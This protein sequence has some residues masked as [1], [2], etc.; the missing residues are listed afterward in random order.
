MKIGEEFGEVVAAH[1]GAAGQNPRKGVS[2][3]DADVVT[4]LCDVIITA[5]V[6]AATVAG[7]AMVAGDLFASRV[8]AVLER[9]FADS[10]PPC[11]SCG[12]L[13][14][15]WLA[16]PFPGGTEDVDA[17]SCPCGHE[18]TLTADEGTA[19]YVESVGGARC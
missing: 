2:A 12:G 18:F 9:A 5:M 16:L 14:S 15:R 3:T 19:A 17:W 1:I 7:G 6:A 13:R 8:D 10:A 11:P 4:E